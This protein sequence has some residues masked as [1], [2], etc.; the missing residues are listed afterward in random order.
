MRRL[1]C[2]YPLVSVAEIGVR[3]ICRN[4][5]ES[6]QSL[7]RNGCVAIS[8]SLLWLLRIANGCALGRCGLR[9]RVRRLSSSMRPDLLRAQ[10]GLYFSVYIQGEPFQ[11]G[12]LPAYFRIRRSFSASNKRAYVLSD[13]RAAIPN[14]NSLKRHVPWSSGPKTL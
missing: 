5:L 11:S 4:L 8:L 14:T 12:R 7:P 1:Y 13:A 3:D 10:P 6:V 2:R 9:D